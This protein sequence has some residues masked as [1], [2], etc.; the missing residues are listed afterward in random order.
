MSYF[1]FSTAMNFIRKGVPVSASNWNF[2]D[3][4]SGTTETKQVRTEDIWLPENR[5]VSELIHGKT[6]VVNVKPYMTKMTLGGIE[7]Y[8]PTNEDLFD[9]WMRADTFLHCTS[10]N[11][12]PEESDDVNL[13][14]HLM[15][16]KEHINNNLPFW[17]LYEQ[18]MIGYHNRFVFIAGT[19]AAN[20]LNATIINTLQQY[21]NIRNMDKAYDGFIMDAG[22]YKD[23]WRDYCDKSQIY[24]NLLT[25]D[26][27]DFDID[28]LIQNLLIVGPVN[29]FIDVGSLIHLQLPTGDSALDH[30]TN[31]LIV[32][33]ESNPNLNWVTLDFQE[34]IS[35]SAKGGW[36]ETT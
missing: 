35:N 22:F 8:I 17:K 5:R 12:Y 6:G 31:Q 29:V 7:N 24:Y 20:K 21:A 4:L 30:V 1:D 32:L 3:R 36:N 10:I 14:F 2:V 11:H 13:T 9:K 23:D 26:S 15:S 19:D 28:M 25:I 34:E 16:G 27:R 33:S 18:E